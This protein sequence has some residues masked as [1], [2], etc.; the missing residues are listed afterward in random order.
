MEVRRIRYIQ[1]K[2]NGC[3]FPL[4]FFILL[5]FS[6]LHLCFFPFYTICQFKNILES[7]LVASILS[8]LL[9]GV[10]LRRGSNHD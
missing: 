2:K 1:F 4:F 7:P 6:I 9:L 8:F 5:F 3:C 10:L